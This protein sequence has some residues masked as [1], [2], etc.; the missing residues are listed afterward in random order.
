MQ[1]LEARIAHLETLLQQTRPDVAL[2]HFSFFESETPQRPEAEPR[3]DSQSQHRPNELPLPL[4]TH[5]QQQ[6]V[7]RASRIDNEAGLEP[8]QL[9]SEVALLCISATGREPHYFGPS[10]AVS[11]SRIASYTMGFHRDKEG[12]QPSD[13][14]HSNE[15]LSRATYATQ[16]HFPSEQTGRKLSQA[17]LDNIHKQ[18][19][20]LH[21]PTFLTW[22]EDCFNASR[23]GDVTHAGDVALYFVLMV[24]A[25]GSLALGNA[26]QSA[27]KAYYT[28]ALKYAAPVLDLDS[29]ESIQCILSCAVYSI[30]SPVGV[31]LWKLS[32][33]AVR[34]C[35]ELGYHRS[36]EKYRKNADPLMKE[37]SKRCFWVAYDID[38]VVSGI[39]GRPPAIP[40]ESIDAEVHSYAIIPSIM[41]SDVMHA[42]FSCHSILMMNA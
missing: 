32:G 7:G 26:H 27:A 29:L 40:D 24:Y 37:M 14:G 22:Q 13:D 25:I 18:Y 5:E 35:I 15:D 34:H 17:Y 8:D 16:E 20:F 30:R 12:P 11:F 2:D 21:R 4:G 1:S 28:M 39:L 6:R 42:P 33:M 31:S 10:S 19:P 23:N 41:N 36:T 3:D 38:R 9:S